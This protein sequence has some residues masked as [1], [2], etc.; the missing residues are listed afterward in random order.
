MMDVLEE[1]KKVDPPVEDSKESTDPS[2]TS[3]TVEESSAATTTTESTVSTVDETIVRATT[4]TAPS[5][6]ETETEKDSA[7]QGFFSRFFRNPFGSS[8]DDSDGPKPSSSTTA[9]E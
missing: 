1:I 2:A 5:E 3:S 8:S 4:S 7:S 9:S 6:T